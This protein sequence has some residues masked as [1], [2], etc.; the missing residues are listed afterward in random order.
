MGSKAKSEV[1]S[2]A[3]RKR[4]GN[5]R[6]QERSRQPAKSVVAARHIWKNGMLIETFYSKDCFGDESSDCIS[7]EIHPGQGRGAPALFYLNVEDA[8]AIIHSL[9]A[10]V[11]AAIEDR[12][13]PWPVTDSNGE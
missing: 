2:A 4:A 3:L 1:K 10:A 7:L 9:S 11:S 5:N 6:S 8:I 12:R 13:P